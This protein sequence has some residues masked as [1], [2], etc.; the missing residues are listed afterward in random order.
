LALPG[1]TATAGDLL[2]LYVGG[3]VGQARV[4]AN[5]PYVGDFRETHAAF[6]VMGGLRPISLV[7]AELAYIGFGH[8]RRLNGAISTD[9]TMTGV[10]ALGILYVPVPIV[11]VYAKAG[12]ARLQSTVTTSI[13]CPPGVFCIK[14]ATPAPVSRTNVGFASGI[15]AQFKVGSFAV[16]GEYERFNAAGGHPS[17]LSLGA[18]WTLL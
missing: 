17:L 15:G 5:A 11:D 3:A 18:T 9:V 1:G 6:K 13:G 12:L 10:A 14:I 2:G 7:G 8:P 16:R 4:D